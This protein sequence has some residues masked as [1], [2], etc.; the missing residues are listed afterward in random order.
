VALAVRKRKVR[1]AAAVPD[2]C[3]VR[4]SR[5]P[6]RTVSGIKGADAGSLLSNRM[7]ATA[8]SW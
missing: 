8:S 6:R 5:W 4:W 3:A 7:Q 1:S 2:P